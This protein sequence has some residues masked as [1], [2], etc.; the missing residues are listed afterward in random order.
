MKVKVKYIV[1][2]TFGNSFV[3]ILYAFFAYLSPASPNYMVSALEAVF[4]ML[5]F[6]HVILAAATVILAMAAWSLE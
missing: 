3:A 6:L 2:G 1:Q 5:A 4:T